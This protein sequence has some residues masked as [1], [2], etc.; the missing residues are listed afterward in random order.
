MM[1]KLRINVVIV[2]PSIVVFEGL[3]SIL[4]KSPHSYYLRHFIEID[5]LCRE[6][7]QYKPDIVIINPIVLINKESMISKLQKKCP[8]VRLIGLLYSHFNNNLLNRFPETISLFDNIKSIENTIQNNNVIAQETDHQEEL[9]EREV[10][11]LRELTKGL[12]N[13]EI[14]D[15]LNISVHTVISHRKNITEKTG[16]KSLPGLTIY[17]I[18]KKIMIIE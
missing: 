13:K 17:A 9:T 8:N 14:A 3:S 7:D 6:S 11:V 18:S 12:S 16:I 15:N 2:E 5:T 1:D 10:D 4:L